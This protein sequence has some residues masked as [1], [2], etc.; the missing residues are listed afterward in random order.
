MQSEGL[1]AGALDISQ[2]PSF[3][4]RLKFRLSVAFGAWSEGDH[5][6]WDAIRAWAEELKPILAP[7]L[8]DGSCITKQVQAD[9]E[10]KASRRKRVNRHNTAEIGHN[11]LVAEGP[12]PAQDVT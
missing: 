9:E 6:D 10:S 8:P 7:N 2:V 4:D 3:R 1:F 11:F 5:G 12:R